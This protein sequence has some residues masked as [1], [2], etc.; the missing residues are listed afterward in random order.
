MTDEPFIDPGPDVYAEGFRRG[1]Y[2]WM[3]D[4]FVLTQQCIEDGMQRALDEWLERD[5]NAEIVL[6]VA[7]TACMTKWLGAQGP[8]LR[9]AIVEALQAKR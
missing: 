6:Q 7:V 2:S 8:A 9:R 4:N 5:H 1:M 3:E